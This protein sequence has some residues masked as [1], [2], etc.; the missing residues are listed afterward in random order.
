[1]I[2]TWRFCS[3]LRLRDWFT[4]F[5]C[6]G[7]CHLGNYW[8]TDPI[9]FHWDRTIIWWPW[10]NLIFYLTWFC[11]YW[12]NCSCKRTM[13][14]RLISNTLTTYC[15]I[16]VWTWSCIFQRWG[17]WLI[18]DCGTI[19]ISFCWY[20]TAISHFFVIIIFFRART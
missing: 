13:Y 15:I 3:F 6:K 18:T 14:T 11:T 1:M 19:S 10:K 7:E 16:V 17:F 2:W 9:N 5:T 8:P 12:P 20:R 4:V